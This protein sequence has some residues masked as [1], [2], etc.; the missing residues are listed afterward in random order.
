[1][2]NRFI[3][4]TFKLS[5]TSS[6][7]SVLFNFKYKFFQRI[8]LATLI[9]TIFTIISFNSAMCVMAQSSL[10]KRLNDSLWAEWKNTAQADSNRLKAIDKLIWS[11]YLFTQPDSA[12]YFAQ[13]QYDLA[14][15][16]VN[17]EAMAAALS[18]QGV[19]FAIKGEFPQALDYTQ[20]C[21]TIYDE[22]DDKVGASNALLNIGSIYLL[23]SDYPTSL[24][25]FQKCLKVFEEIGNK[26][27]VSDVLGNIGT[28]YSYQKNYQTAL[29]YHNRSIGISEEIGDLHGL[30]G[31]QLSAGNCMM[32]LAEFEQAEMLIQKSLSL[33]KDLGDV[34][35]LAHGYTSMGMINNKTKD[36]KQA[37]IWCTKGLELA[38]Q[39]S[40]FDVQKNA[41][42]CLFLAHKT[43]GNTAAALKYHEQMVGLR[44]STLNEETTKKITRL[45]MQYDFDK[46]EAQTKAE[47]EKQNALAA[48]E[49]KRQKTVKK[50]FMGGFAV[51]LLFAG[52]VFVQRNRI[53]KEKKRSEELLLNILP[54][55]TA[56]ELKAKGSSDA[57][58]IDHVTVLFTD[59]KGFTAISEQLSP[60]ELVED[61]N[62]CFSAFDR[63]C[64][65]YGIEKIKTIGDA[66]MAAGGLP[67]P[68]HTHALDVV[69]AA[70][71]IRNFM[72]EGKAKKIL[73]NQPYFEIRIG[74][75]TGPVVAGI[76]G[77]KKFQYDI[78]GDT[79]NTAS[80]ME[81]SGKEGKVNISQSTFELVRN[82][83]GFEFQNRG[84]IEAKGKGE[85]AM[86]FVEQKNN[87]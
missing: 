79:V 76:V 31:G 23:L 56:K 82:E 45:E 14:E 19:V 6:L 66:Y 74:V 44:D 4:S 72:E 3:P 16:S 78:W 67:T 38:E 54:E 1:M 7:K 29:D 9:Q 70:L 11:G 53:S 41:C 10:P 25:Y 57:K 21:L 8:R 42:E 34:N 69:N 15:K 5:K 17:K 33:F 62:E 18:S 59:F 39:I 30:A 2:K 73:N 50:G 77:V 63:I 48:Q 28:I 12:L 68:N 55:E 51:V 87:E 37:L 65:K 47:Q 49:I 64:G 46:K 80:R 60:K 84:K 61:L 36:H 58:L 26:K 40:V 32:E 22:I 20:R 13:L 83:S 24:E 85:I 52:I 35:G 27:G 75:N 71:E 86:Y 43:L 81:S